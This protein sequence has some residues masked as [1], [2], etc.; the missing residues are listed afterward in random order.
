MIEEFV[1]DFI[2]SNEDYSVRDAIA[3]TVKKFPNYMAIDAVFAFVSMASALEQPIF[4]YTDNDKKISAQLYR[5]IAMFIADI[6]AVEKLKGWPVTC[7]QVSD[8]WAEQ[9]DT[10]FLPP[11]LTQ[12]N[13]NL[14]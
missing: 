13:T 5:S 9:G 11:D 2:V 14:T 1:A 8:F 10:F 7:V 3:A 12:L 4:R 6:Y